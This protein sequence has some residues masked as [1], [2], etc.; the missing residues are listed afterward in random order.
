MC[1]FVGRST[2]TATSKRGP[3]GCDDSGPVAATSTRSCA[4]TTWVTRRGGPGRS[5]NSADSPGTTVDAV[6]DHAAVASLLGRTP[7]GAFD[8]VVRQASG[9]PIVIR[10]APLLADGTPMPTLYWLVDDRLR[11]A[12]SRLESVGGVKAAEADV[13][14]EELAAAHRRYAEERDAAL[15][16]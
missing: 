12:V 7:Q 16:V 15:S 13:D 14:H 4:T 6:D 8:V 5:K 1:D 10:N 3:S 11:E 2:P 9:A